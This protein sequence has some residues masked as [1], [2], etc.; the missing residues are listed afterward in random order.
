MILLNIKHASYQI[1]HYQVMTINV[2]YDLKYFAI[3]NYVMT[4]ALT[5]DTRHGDATTHRVIKC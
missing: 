1:L 5:P 4:L 2:S 3:P